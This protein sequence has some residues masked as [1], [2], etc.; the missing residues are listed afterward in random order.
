MVASYKYGEILEGDIEIELY[1]KSSVESDYL[2]IGFSD[3]KLMGNDLVFAFSKSW[4]KDF[5]PAVAIVSNP[6]RKFW[7]DP[8]PGENAKYSYEYKKY[9]D[10]AMN[11]SIVFEDGKIC[12]S[13]SL[14]RMQQGSKL[15]WFDLSSPYFLLLASGKIGKITTHEVEQ[16]DVEIT[17]HSMKISSAKKTRTH[18]GKNLIHVI[19]LLTNPYEASRKKLRFIL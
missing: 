14:D 1:K 15:D 6:V 5:S 10:S 16:A 17:K 7:N 3:D 2:A 4:D 19:S 11:R 8:S 18:N 9:I 12:C 13:F